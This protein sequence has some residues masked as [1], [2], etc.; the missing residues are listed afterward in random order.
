MGSHVINN[1]ALF[2]HIPTIAQ[3]PQQEAKNVAGKGLA[4]NFYAIL[5]RAVNYLSNNEKHY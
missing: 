5:A 4:V 1:L 3:Q 2:K